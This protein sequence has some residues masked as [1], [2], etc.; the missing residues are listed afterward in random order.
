M[1]CQPASLRG[2]PAPALATL[3]AAAAL[4]AALLAAAPAPAAAQQHPESFYYENIWSKEPFPGF[5]S[6]YLEQHPE[7]QV[8]IHN[9]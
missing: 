9:A 4:A 1:P 6:A 2:R 8:D 5:L 7:V 3:L